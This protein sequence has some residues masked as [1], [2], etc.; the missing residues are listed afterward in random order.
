[1]LSV[2]SVDV[3]CLLDFG[4]LLG[5]PLRI[6]E[7]VLVPYLQPITRYHFFLCKIYDEHLEINET[8]S[9]T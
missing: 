4:L 9:R 8:F 7:F 3:V 2:Q 5:R 1:M 6:F